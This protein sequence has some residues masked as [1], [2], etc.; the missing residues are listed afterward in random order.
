MF[1]K[2]SA[3]VRF[4]RFSVAACLILAALTAF[5]GLAPAADQVSITG[6]PASAAPGAT[7]D[8]HVEWE[9]DA[10][11]EEKRIVVL[12]ELR[13]SSDDAL[14]TRQIFNNSNNGYTAASGSHDATLTIPAN[15]EGAH[16]IQAWLAPWSLNR[17]MVEKLETYPTDGTFTYLWG[18]GGYGVTQNVYYLNELICPKP[19]GDTTYCSGL[20]FEAF[21]LGYKDY[22]A[23]MGHPE[24]IGTLTVAGMK[25]FRLVWYG[26]TDAEKLAAR[27][28][29]EYG[30]G[31][32]ITDFEEAQK[33]D[34]LQFWRH[35]G[36]GHNPVF[37]NW[38][39]NTQGDIT[40]VRYWGSQGSTNGIG[41]N[42]ENF[43]V[44]SGINPA[45]VYL[46]RARKPRD[47][48]D[49]Q[50]ASAS[51]DTKLSPTLVGISS[52]EGWMMH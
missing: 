29:P 6:A 22:N 37:M 3:I 8:I 47:D 35:S 43:G 5:A 10:D 15:A 51:A 4:W 49:Y 34:A 7:L 13:R 39:R 42:Q 19:A 14:I 31:V 41:Y 46:G 50:W 1:I 18:G 20:A 44:S 25:N 36:S 17:Q 24:T 2:S 40:G 11:P 21:V 52:V 45:R 26:V 27:A 23:A 48:A 28:I 32:E 30:L 9:R 38:L 12:V 33:G 16:Y